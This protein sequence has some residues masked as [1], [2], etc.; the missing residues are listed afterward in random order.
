MALDVFR[1][2]DGMITEIMTFSP[3]VFEGFG[4]PS[5]LKATS[6]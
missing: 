4:L 6:R 1:I 3:S 2:E 5:R